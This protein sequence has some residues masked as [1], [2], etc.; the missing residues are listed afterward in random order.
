[1]RAVIRDRDLPAR[2]ATLLASCVWGKLA[3]KDLV[4]WVL[5]D[6]LPALRETVFVS[7]EIDHCFPSGEP[8]GESKAGSTSAGAR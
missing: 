4:A 2:G 3:P 7:S 6:A 8:R 1:M 5:E